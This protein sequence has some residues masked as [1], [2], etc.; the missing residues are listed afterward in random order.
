M[1][2]RPCQCQ[3]CGANIS[4]KRCW[5]PFCSA[6]LIAGGEVVEG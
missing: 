4:E 5:C 3:V 1:R 6:V 2:G